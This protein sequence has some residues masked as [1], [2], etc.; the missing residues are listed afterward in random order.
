MNSEHMPTEER[1]TELLFGK[2][3]I[4]AV[5]SD[6]RP[7]RYEDGPTGY[8]TLDDGTVLKVWG[9]TGGCSCGA[10]DYPLTELNA[11]DNVITNVVLDEKPDG[12]DVRCE[13]C[14]KT[15]G[16]DHEGDRGYYR[17]FVYAEDRRIT[18]ASFDGS[19]GNGY[20]GTGWWLAVTDA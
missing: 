15:W 8:L 11:C 14:G 20:Y 3:I 2:K 16:C 4:S 1:L 9:N 7:E 13:T 10:G 6:E 19:D 18:L 5:M 17:I 12:D